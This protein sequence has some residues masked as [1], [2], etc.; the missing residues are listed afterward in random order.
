VVD[1]I[2]GK[3]M[4]SHDAHDNWVLCVAYSPDGKTIATCSNDGIISVWDADNGSRLLGPF[5]CHVG[6]V[7]SIAFSPD[8]NVL[9]SG[10][11][12]S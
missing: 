11:A 12:L 3:V 1:A 2:A 9:L 8:G 5:N 10:N 6:A 7:L 4:F